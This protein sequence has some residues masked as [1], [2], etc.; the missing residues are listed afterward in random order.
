[1][2]W[3]LEGYEKQGYLRYVDCNHNGGKKAVEP[4]NL[5]GTLL[6]LSAMI[7]GFREQGRKVRFVFDNLTTLL[8][9]NGLYRV[10]LFLQELM[11][12]LKAAEATSVFILEDG[13]RDKE[14]TR[15]LRSMS[16]SVLE[17]NC[18]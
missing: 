16:D 2:G 11:G 17:L 10:V 12:R 5:E 9:T 4:E 13:V 1:M 3:N 6:M 7:S 14:V 18:S 15:V 8:D